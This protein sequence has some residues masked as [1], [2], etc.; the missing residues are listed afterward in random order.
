MNV[1]EKVNKA[2][3]DLVSSVTDYSTQSIVAANTTLQL[4]PEQLDK[5]S[6]LLPQL[7]TAGAL[8]AMPT[9]QRTIAE[10]LQD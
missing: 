4:S 6:R 10:Y 7:M 3:Q 8:R 1:Q 9:F 2:A 5:L